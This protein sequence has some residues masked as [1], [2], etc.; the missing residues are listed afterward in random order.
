MIATSR[1]T[2]AARPSPPAPGVRARLERPAAAAIARRAGWPLAVYAGFAAGVLAVTWPLVLDPATLWP[3]HHDSR[4]FTWVMASIGRRLL[5]DPR[6]LFH[7]N[8]FYPFGDSLAFTEVLLPPSLLGLPGFR[9]GKPVLTYNLLLLALWPLNGLAMTLVARALTGSRTA[10]LV[11]GTVFCLSPYFTTYYLEFQMLLAAA[12]PVVLWAWLR[13]LETARDRWL[14]LALGGLAVQALTSWYYAVILAL[15][16]VTVTAAALALRWRG[17]AWRR[18]LAP[19]ALGLAALGGLLLPF[20][21]PYFAVHRELAY[22]RT[23]G[24]TAGHYADVLSF[25]EPSERSLFYRYSLTGHIAETAPFVGFTTLALAV[26]AV[27][28]LRPGGPRTPGVAR[29]WRG[30][31]A[32]LAGALGGA[33]WLATRAHPVAR[34]KLGHASIVHL[35]PGTL[36]DVAVLLGIALLV[37]EG[38]T[39]RRNPERR[40]GADGWVRCLVL[41]AGVSAVLALGPIIHLARREIGAGPYLGLYHVLLPLHVIRVTTRFAVLTVAALA[42]LAAFGV[43]AMQWA[44]GDWPRLSRVV[45]AGIFVALAT[46]YAVQP[47][48]Y[49]PAGMAPRP[50]DVALRAD[51]DEVAV[52]EWPINVAN[53]D[54]D[55][56]VHSLFHGKLL[57]NGLSGVIPPHLGHLSDLL[58]RVTNPFPSDEAQAALR[59]LYPLRYLVVRTSRDPEWAALAAHPPP[60]LRLVGHFRR[61]DLYRVEPLPERG[62]WIERWVSYDFLRRHPVLRLAVRPLDEPPGLRD[63]AVELVVD[64]AP[65]R[66]FGLAGPVTGRLTLPPPRLAVVPTTIALV[67]RYAL[68]PGVRDARFT[69]GNTGVLSPGDLRIVSMGPGHGHRSSIRLNG[70]EL[71]PAGGDPCMLVAIDDTGAGRRPD[72]C[73]EDAL[74]RWLA[75][76]PP[77]TIVAGVA[78]DPDRLGP[79]VLRAL[80]ALGGRPAGGAAA[81]PYAVVGVTGARAGSAREAYGADR[82][83]IVIGRADAPAGFELTEFELLPGP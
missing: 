9:W 25:L 53:D 15:G 28:R 30:L 82:A 60:L 4:V 24:E 33:A 7:G 48:V 1:A 19:L 68:A 41:L 22:E 35:R 69:I 74:A 31:L 81:G 46:E 78:R 62:T 17:W 51:P 77:G 80:G 32:A 59:R 76:L 27:G 56:M 39:S 36:L 52:L 13:W 57:V 42:L 64:G 73:R 47:A 3:P 21:A 58:S 16:L 11:A 55:A 26:V 20:A 8:A 23:L 38:W 75:V 66:R 61:E 40:L 63:V 49:R 71:L 79:A 37:L 65:V 10:G 18:R 67:H 5:R 6:A 29:L 50:V 2:G 44:L 14:A 72:R 70:A 54:A 34:A 12:I 83:D 43:R 45:Q